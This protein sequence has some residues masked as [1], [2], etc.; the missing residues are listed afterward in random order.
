MISFIITI[1]LI[2]FMIMLGVVFLLY[3]EN[4]ELRKEL[5]EIEKQKFRDANLQKLKE[6]YNGGQKR[7]T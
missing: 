6:V 5:R 1:V 7:N 4:K 3:I 2:V